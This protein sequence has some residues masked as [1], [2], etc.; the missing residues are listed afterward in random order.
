MV[1]VW[2]CVRL[3]RD[4]ANGN[5]VVGSFRVADLDDRDRPPHLFATGQLSASTDHA[6]AVAATNESVWVGYGTTIVELNPTDLSER[7]R[8]SVDEA[9]L[10]LA[11]TPTGLVAISASSLTQFD[12][13]G[14]VLSRTDLSVSNPLRVTEVR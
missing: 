12:A 1:G 3:N 11:A 6:P 2:L 13:H 8:F 7:Q 4:I 5:G 10:A 14:V 9:A